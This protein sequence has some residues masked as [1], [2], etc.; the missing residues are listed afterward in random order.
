MARTQPRMD[1]KMAE[2]L[3]EEELK[4]AKPKS[5][6]PLL[7]VLLLVN[8]A[9][10][11]AVA[12]FQWQ[13]HQKWASQSSVSDINKAITAEGI[14]DQASAQVSKKFLKDL[15]PFTVNLAQGDGPRRF[16][17]VSMVLTFD[18]QV[19]DSAFK[20]IEPRVRDSIINLLNSKRPEDL[21]KE[22]GKNILKEEIKSAIN[23]FLVEGNVTDI[24]YVNF[25]IN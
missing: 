14:D 15:D 17:R 1:E 5:S 12:Y 4:E 13:S 6:N 16:A 20:P 23:S 2:E 25:Q 19:N 3:T 22:E 7:T 18:E 21:L 8:C 11:G 10:M 24:Y 9:L